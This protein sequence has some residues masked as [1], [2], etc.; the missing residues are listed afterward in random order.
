M[1][2]QETQFTLP[3]NFL[4]HQKEVSARMRAILVD[5]IVEVHQRFKLRQETLF[6]TVNLLDRF[7]AKRNIS[8]GKL[9]LLGTTCLWL[10][11]KFE[12]MY[13]PEIRDFEYITD[14]SCTRYEI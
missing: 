11:C 12:E 10:A 2:S 5:W 6:L 13:Q 9:Q 7:L 14:R 4:S 3:T 8:K 1:K